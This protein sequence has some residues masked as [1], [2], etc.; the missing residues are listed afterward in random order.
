MAQGSISPLSLEAGAGLLNNTGIGVGSALTANIAAYTST[1][2]ISKLLTIQT[3]AAASSLTTAT[4]NSLTTMGAS[5]CPALGDSVPTAYVNTAYPIPPVSGAKLIPANVLL[6][7]TVASVGA[8]YLG[9]GD[10]GKFCQAYFSSSGYISLVNPVI[11]S[12]ANANTNYLGPTFAGMDSLISGSLADINLAFPTFG[13]DLENLG[14]TLNLANLPAMGSPSGLL[15]AL[16]IAGNMPGGT[17]PAVRDALL[18]VGL[19]PDEITDLVTDNQQNNQQSLFNP[20]GLLPNDFDALQKRAYPA[21]CNVTGADLQ[22]VLDILDC[23][24]PNIT[25]MCELLNPVK[26]LPNSYLSLT[27]PNPAGPVP[28]LVYTPTGQISDTVDRVVNTGA[29]APVGC[30]ELAKIVPPANAV[31]SKAMLIAFQQVKGIDTMTLPNL[32]AALKN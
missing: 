1:T 14:F 3:L 24:T 8:S 11:L 4:K 30:D 15:Q 7:T 20:N 10:V 21:L 25:Q 28:L 6:T 17:T 26:I 19:T 12:A 23:V 9:A 22:Q 27:I 13:Q 5:T 29:L 32:A 18:A 16:S 2:T 31:G